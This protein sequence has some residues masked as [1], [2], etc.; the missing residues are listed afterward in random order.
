MADKVK[1]LKLESSSTGGTE[2]DFFQTEVN[3]TEDYVAAKGIAL[4]NNDNRLV[5][6]DGSGNIQFKDAVETTPITVRK[7]RTA[8]QNIFDNTLNGFIA[9]DV[10]AAIEESKTS[11]PGK[12]RA[13]VTCTFNGAIGNNNWLGY[14]ELLPGDTVPIRVPWNSTL[15][16]ITVSYASGVAV[17]G[18]LVIYKNGTAAGNIV[19]T[20]TFTNQSN[21]KNITLSLSLTSGDTIRGRWTDTGD[22]PSDMA[23]VYFFL[24]V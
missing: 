8:N 16:E 3:P 15:K 4:E 6:L 24:L 14:N 2:N 17:D 20:E 13:S 11:A 23:I 1:P 19:H 9:T 12:A 7:L 22:N 5:D 10:Q 18:R 21:G